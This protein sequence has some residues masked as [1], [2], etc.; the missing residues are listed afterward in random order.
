MSSGNRDRILSAAHHRQLKS[1]HRA[2][3]RRFPVSNPA[4]G[5]PE[6]P[7][8][9]GFSQYSFPQE[10]VSTRLHEKSTSRLVS[11]ARFEFYITTL[12]FEANDHGSKHAK[13]N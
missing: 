2:E 6:D 5:C 3:A 7:E 10:N 11:L 12:R 9:V 13:I 4:R 1:L 8:R